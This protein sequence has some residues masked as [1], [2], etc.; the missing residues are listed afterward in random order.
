VEEMRTLLEI[1]VVPMTGKAK[2]IMVPINRPV[3]HF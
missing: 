3:E 1:T 2:S